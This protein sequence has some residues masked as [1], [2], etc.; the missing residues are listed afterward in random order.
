MANISKGEQIIQAVR[1]RKSYGD[2]QILT[3]IS[4]AFNYGDRIGFLGV[5][6]A[7]KSTL[8]KI[9]AGVDKQFEGQLIVRNDITRGYVPQEQIGRASC[10]ERV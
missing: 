7:G 6:G 4:F 2:K 8:M 3:G 5:N 10:R 1:L 9:I